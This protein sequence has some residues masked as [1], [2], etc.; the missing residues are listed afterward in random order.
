MSK[1]PILTVEDDLHR[2]VLS[3]P[4]KPVEKDK[5]EWVKGCLA[6]AAKEYKSMA[7]GLSAPQVGCPARAFVFIVGDDLTFF[8]NPELLKTGKKTNVDEEHCLSVPRKRFRVKRYSKITVRDEINGK[9]VLR[10]FAARVWQH[11]FDHLEG[12]TL[13]DTG[14]EVT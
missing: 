1:T 13:L 3:H 2:K 9:L 8:R 4:V 6:K 12:K 7:V 5:W 10:G 11:E 14:E